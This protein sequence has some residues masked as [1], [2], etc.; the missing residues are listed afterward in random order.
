M[1]WKFWQKEHASLPL[2]IVP[3]EQRIA[4]EAWMKELGVSSLYTTFK[5]FED[6]LLVKDVS[7]IPVQEKIERIRT[8]QRITQSKYDRNKLLI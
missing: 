6:P 7:I 8:A 2:V 1:N 4:C 5:P 3:E